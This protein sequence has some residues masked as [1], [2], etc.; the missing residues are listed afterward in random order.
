MTREEREDGWR[1]MEMMAVKVRGEGW[2]RRE[3]NEE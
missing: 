3:S 2:R 1:K